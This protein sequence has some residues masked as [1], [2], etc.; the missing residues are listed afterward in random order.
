MNKWPTHFL[1]AFSALL[2]AIGS[3]AIDTASPSVPVAAVDPVAATATSEEAMVAIELDRLLTTYGE[4]VSGLG[5]WACESC[6]ILWIWEGHELKG[7]AAPGGARR[8]AHIHDCTTYGS[9]GQ[10]ESCDD[11]DGGRETMSQ[12]VRTLRQATPTVLAAAVARHPKVL[13][14]NA[15]RGALQLVGCGGAVVASYP[16]ATPASQ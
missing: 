13:R 14:F 12:I 16:V 7:E 6:K 1:P 10:H 15:D 11:G 5:C 3:S 8:G 9:C 4:T 2:L